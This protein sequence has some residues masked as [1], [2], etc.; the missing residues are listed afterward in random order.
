MMKQSVRIIGGKLR[1]RKIH[2]P[3]IPGLRP[4]A[5]RVRETLFN[6]LMHDIRDACVLDAFAGSG[7]LGFEAASRGAANVIMVESSPEAAQSLRKQADILALENVNIVCQDVLHY[8]QQT[9]IAFD[10]V[11]L[12][13]PFASEL[14][15][16]SLDLIDQRGLL[17]QQGLV[18]V[19]TNANSPFDAPF[20]QVMKEK[21]AGQVRYRLLKR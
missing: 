20:M 11:F 21:K 10:I 8:L 17:S 18:Y 12:D 14:L 6:W 4:T 9:T 5:D 1:G 3:D 7:A 15:L 16:P 19:E 13:P 2:F